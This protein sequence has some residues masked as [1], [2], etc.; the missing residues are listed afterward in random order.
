MKSNLKCI[1]VSKYFRNNNGFK[2]QEYVLKDIKLEIKEND[3]ITILG[4][5]GTGK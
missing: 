5:S 4:P 1:N 3:F 2:N